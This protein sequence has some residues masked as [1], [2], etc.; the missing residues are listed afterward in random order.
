M[1]LTGVTKKLIK[2]IHTAVNN[3]AYIY[4]SLLMLLYIL[5]KRRKILYSCESFRTFYE[6][7]QHFVDF[8]C[9]FTLA[10]FH[11]ECKK[12]KLCV[13]IC[14]NEINKNSMHRQIIS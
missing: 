1:A 13:I 3:T 7:V 12:N 14:H 10:L 11:F 2:L 6:F 8:F 4:K 5:K 9:C